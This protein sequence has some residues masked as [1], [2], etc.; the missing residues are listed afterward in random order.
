ML[1]R[2]THNWSLKLLALAIATAMW[3][4]V[5]GQEKSEIGV[6]VAVEITNLPPELLVV[7]DHPGEVDVRVYG[8]RSLIRRVASER[9]V[10][11]VDLSGM[12]LGEHVFQV[13]PED[14]RLPP[15][16][17]VI[18]I[19]PGSF[20]LTL[21][22]RITRDVQVR[23]VFRG[24][25]QA[26]FEVAEVTFKPEK[27]VVWGRKEDLGDLDW[28]WTVPIDLTDRHDSFNQTVQLRLPPGRTVRVNQVE[29]VAQVKIAPGKQP[30][31][32]PAPAGKAPK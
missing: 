5:V 31:P 28:I 20:T 26:G 18:R 29:V 30:T 23:P 2:I 19:S 22:K 24:H 10:K 1:E 13:L 27:V 7:E 9:L 25:P 32:A 17:R 21:A 16:V 14:L 12:G 4:F 6:R 8:P 11:V 3:V 15:G